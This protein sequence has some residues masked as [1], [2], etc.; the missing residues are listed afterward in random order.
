MEPILKNYKKDRRGRLG[1]EG[2][3][4]RIEGENII[5]VYYVYVWKCHDETLTLHNTY[6]LMKMELEKM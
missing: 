6:V 4:K 5:K 2:I 3:R 1:A